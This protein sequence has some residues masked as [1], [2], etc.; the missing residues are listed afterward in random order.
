MAD[1][2]ERRAEDELTIK[3]SRG[4]GAM[5]NKFKGTRSREFHHR[6]SFK[7]I[8]FIFLRTTGTYTYIAEDQTDN[9]VTNLLKNIRD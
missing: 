1:K 5:Y 9:F 3:K 4:S 2:V 6:F 8:E 7:S